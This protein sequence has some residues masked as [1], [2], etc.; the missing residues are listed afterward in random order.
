MTELLLEVVAP[1]ATL[2]TS[3]GGVDVERRFCELTGARMAKQ[4]SPDGDAVLN[5]RYVEIKAGTHGHVNRVRPMKYLT[6]VV[7]DARDASW[8][9]VPPHEVVR[10]VAHHRRGFDTEIAL[11]CA[12]LGPASYRHF[13]VLESDLGD[14]VHR[15]TLEGDLY[16]DLRDQLQLIHGEIA[17]LAKAARK[18]VTALL[19]HIPAPVSQA[20]LFGEEVA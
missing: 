9:V 5:G 17:N 3:N 12:Q 19:E 16:P 6:M 20:T 13:K 8:Y 14:A 11:E 15:A 2:G 4:K 1:I 7:Y 18:R 10:L